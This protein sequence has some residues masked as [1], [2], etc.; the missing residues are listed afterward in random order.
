MKVVS[1]HYGT[2]QKNCTSSQ[3]RCQ[4]TKIICIACNL[5]NDHIPWKK[6][7]TSGPVWAIVGAQTCANYGNYTVLS[8]I[9]LYMK[10]VLK[11]DIKKVSHT[12]I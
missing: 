2:S 9:P 11:F 1:V 6:I 7:F 10:D 5:Q 8:C 12:C 3:L 4:C